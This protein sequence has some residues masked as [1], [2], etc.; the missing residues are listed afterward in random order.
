MEDSVQKKVCTQI[1]YLNT[2][3]ST[4]K[5]AFFSFEIEDNYK[6]SDTVDLVPI[7]KIKGKL[8]SNTT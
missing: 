6:L 3:N 8:F 1:Q 4:C 5:G 2:Q 7:P